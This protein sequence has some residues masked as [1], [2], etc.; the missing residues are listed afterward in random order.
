DS[1]TSID[2][3]AFS[4]CSSLTNITILDGVTSIGAAAFSCC[5]SLTSITI[6]DSVTSIGDRPFDDCS[7]LTSIQV[8]ANNP[9]Y[10]S[11]GGVLF[12]KDITTLVAYPGG[13]KGAYTIPDG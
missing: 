12:N 11:E 2:E 9:S 13:L 3:F 8:N 10:A 5:T 1:V 7:S 4:R 6:P